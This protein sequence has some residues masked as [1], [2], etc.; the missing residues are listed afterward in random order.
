MSSWI[1]TVFPTPAPPKSPIFPPFW[2]GQSKSTTF[3]PVSSISCD[4]ACSSKLGAGLWIAHFSSVCGGSTSSIG[5][6]STLNILPS[7]F[8]PTGTEIGAP[9]AIASMPR[10]RPSVGPMAIH[11]TVSSPR[12]CATS[13]T[14]F[15]PFFSGTSTASFISGRL[16]SENLI[17]RT[18]LITC[19]I[20]PTFLSAIYSFSFFFNSY[21]TLAFLAIHRHTCL[22]SHDRICMYHSIALAPAIISVSS[23]VI[24]P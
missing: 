22:P 20:L 11:L 21:D 6:P 13:T 3:I 7:V 1:S 9:V 16:P 19:M 8:S 5:S 12:C 24:E 2:Y 17:S 18:A 23:C 4:V 10:T 15:P 14:S